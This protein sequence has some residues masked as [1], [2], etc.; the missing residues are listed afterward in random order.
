MGWASLEI[1]FPVDLS[2][3]ENPNYRISFSE[4]IRF[5]G[6]FVLHVSPYEATLTSGTRCKNIFGVSFGM[7]WTAFFIATIKAHY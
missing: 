1:M 4:C 6:V 3:P 7:R 2:V 5:Y